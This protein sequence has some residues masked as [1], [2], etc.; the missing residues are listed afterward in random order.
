[1]EP[2]C[3]EWPFTIV[4]SYGTGDSNRRFTNALI[5]AQ[6]RHPGLVEEI[7]FGGAGALSSP[8]DVAAKINENI[9]WR[10]VC[11]SRGI[12]FSYQQGVTLNHD[13]D[14]RHEGF[15]DDAWVVD[16]DGNRLFGLL[17]PTSPE[18]F[19]ANRRV[20]EK[21]MADMQPDSYW[22]DD[23]LRFSKARNRICFCDRC[24]ELFNRGTNRNMTRVELVEALFGKGKDA[25]ARSDWKEFHRRC[26]GDFAKVYRAAA[27]KVLPSCRLGIQTVSTNEHYDGSDYKPL[28]EA[29]SGPGLK[30]VGIRPGS[31]FYTDNHPWEMVA[32]TRN[33]MVE[34][35]RCKKYG[36]VKQVC[37]ESENWPHVSAEKNPSFQMLE[38][39]LAIACGCDSIAHYWGSDTNGETDENYEYWFELLAKWKPYFLAIRDAFA[40]TQP[41]GIAPYSGKDLNDA[42]NWHDWG[43]RD[44]YTIDYLS[45]NSVPTCCEDGLVEARWINARRVAELARE[46]LDVVF[47]G[48]VMMDVAAFQALRQKFPELG[49]VRKVDVKPFAELS[50]A[51]ANIGCFEVF[52]CGFKARNV[53]GVYL[54]KGDGVKAF[55]EIEDMPGACGTC[56]VET[57]FG[58]SVVLFQSFDLCWLWTGPRRKAILDALDSISKN[59]HGRI[60]TGGYS[61]VPYVRADAAGNTAGLFLLN[62]GCGE[63]PPLKLEIRNPAFE[64]W[65]GL[66]ENGSVALRCVRE[67]DGRI[68]VEIPSMRAWSSILVKGA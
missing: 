45:R 44:D 36:I 61:V 52:P 65:S 63:T 8:E 51:T 10:E 18:A 49:F 38:C 7:W 27:D 12:A 4:R 15:S 31:G 37:Y 9:G 34:A 48:P 30:P 29:L 14:G 55:S 43:A 46:D 64:K 53:V 25:S 40:R 20:A 35:V 56:T 42:D 60:L 62:G 6:D 23:D 24:I 3:H 41:C 28:L 22:P 16:A 66:D 58:G 17:C 21:V 68:V 39:A 33:V 67:A 11:K 26:L 59:V 5:A 32:K 1:M 2:T 13:A 47:S 50:P 19:E 57:E 54:P